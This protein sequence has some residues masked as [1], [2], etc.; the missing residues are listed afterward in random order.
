MKRES[1]DRDNG[2][3]PE[4][5][6]PYH[7]PQHKND[8]EKIALQSGKVNPADVGLETSVPDD[9]LMPKPA[10]PSGPPQ[11][12]KKSKDPKGGRP[13][14]KKDEKPRKKRTEKP[15]S[16]PGVADPVVWLENAWSEIS[17]ILNKAF[18]GTKN[19]KNLRQLTK[20]EVSELESLKLAVFTNTEL[21][22]KVHAKA[23]YETVQSGLSAP[24]GFR[25]ILMSKGITV[26]NLSIDDYRKHLLGSY[27]E[28]LL[29]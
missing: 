19:K 14:L 15:K 13:L 29:V 17:Q 1:K 21:F 27:L 3:V 18:L 8:L 2:K 20:A 22:S 7:N 11:D 6:S 28:F 25:N 12:E 23:V 10:P 26:E 16:K 5:A 4:K 9:I 24:A